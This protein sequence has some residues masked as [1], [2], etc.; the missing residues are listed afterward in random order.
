MSGEPMPARVQSLWQ[1]Q[2][3]E[4]GAMSVDELRRR[5]RRLTRIVSRRNL[6]EYV[7]AAVV[8]VAFGF[9]A[10]KAPLPLMRVA[11]V[12]S[13]AGM[14]FVVYHLHRH[15]AARAMPADMGLTS[16]LQFH[17]GELERQRDLL[18]GVWK[19]YL[20]P[21]VPGMILVYLAAA[22]AHPEHASRAVWGLGGSL[23][24]FVLIGELNRR[25]AEKL[26]LR[27]DALEKDSRI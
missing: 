8:V 4:S 13:V 17:R 6:R 14:I 25:V 26:Q 18:R 23:V 19:W 11:D 21:L 2:P 3:A 16:C 22:L 20:A 24:L 27:I 12:L 15:G 1:D 9:M 7:A 10:W 5:S